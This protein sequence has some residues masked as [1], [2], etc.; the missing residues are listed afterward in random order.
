M[1][2]LVQRLDATRNC[3]KHFTCASAEILGLIGFRNVDHTFRDSPIQ[4]V[5]IHLENRDCGRHLH[6]G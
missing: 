1:N 4:L 5:C 3:S 6:L 2:W